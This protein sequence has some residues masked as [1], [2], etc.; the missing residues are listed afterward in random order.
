MSAFNGWLSYTDVGLM[1]HTEMHGVLPSL[2]RS[3]EREGYETSFIYAGQMTNMGKREY[4]EN[5]GFRHL[6]DDTAFS[7]D[8]ASGSWGVYDSISC[9]KAVEIVP[10]IAGRIRLTAQASTPIYSL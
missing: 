4:L 3:L 9:Q 2:P 8:Q 6:Y 1:K 10:Y 7:A 5:V